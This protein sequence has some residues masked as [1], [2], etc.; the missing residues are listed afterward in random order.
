M[1]GVPPRTICFTS[2]G[3][4]AD[5]HAIQAAVSCLGVKRII[6]SAAEH[7]AVIKATQQA[8]DR[9]QL[10]LVHV[11]H[12]E[13]GQVDM[14]HLAE[15]L[16]GSEKKTLVSLMHA[17]NE[18]GVMVDLARLSALCSEHGALL[19]SDTVQTM[20]HYPLDLNVA[21][22]DYLASIAHNLHGP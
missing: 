2:G 13:D 3:T 15:L 12:H 9:H 17:N 21:D 8:S 5:N 14:G 18:V 11:Q 1:L 4:E 22:V 10:E 16:V 7:S 6:T 20:G 19:H